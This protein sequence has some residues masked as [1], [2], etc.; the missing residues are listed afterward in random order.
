MQTPQLLSAMSPSITKMIRADHSHVMVTS[1]Q[2]SADT[3]A[4]RKKA[5]ASTVMAALEIHA[6]LEEEIFYP[7]LQAVDPGDQVLQQAKP[8]H[9]E[10]RR[11]IG[12][13]RQTEPDSPRHDTLFA[14]LMREV[15]HHV[16]DEETVL[17]P[18]AERLLK[19]R[20]GELGAQMTKRRLQLVG[21]RVGEIAVNATRA[22]PVS[23][24]LMAGGLFLAGML[25][26][27]QANGR[28]SSPS[29]RHG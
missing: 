6:Q 25:V 15:I 12:E 23:T 11:L 5:I 14:T 26:A 8:Q 13:L 20:L 17:L 9:D 28:S 7:A 4:D 27:R 22:M 21:P 10:M 2:Y 29:R 16:A 24:V 19:E 3:A 1:H 18:L